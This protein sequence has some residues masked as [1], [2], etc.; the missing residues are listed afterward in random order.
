MEKYL[1]DTY[2]IT[3]FQEQVM[4]QSR[5]LGG[6][7][8]GQS[9]TLRK[10]MGK[11]KFDLMAQLKIKFHDGCLANEEFIKG[12]EETNKNPDELINK[13]WKDWES[14]AQYAFNKSH[15]VC[16]ALLAYQTGYLKANYPAEYMSAVMSRNLSDIKK[17]SLFMEECRRMG[18]T[19][20]GPS[21]QE[22]Y[23]LFTVDGD[24]NIRFG[25]NAIKGVGTNTVSEI[26][27][28][29]KA[30]GKFKDI[31][32]FVSR[33]NLSQVNKKSME[34]LVFAGGFDCFEKP[35]RHEFLCVD[36][37]G[38]TF[39]EALVRYGTQKQAEVGGA[40]IWGDM[41]DNA[42]QTPQ[43]PEC[44][45]WSSL[46][47]LKKEKEHIGIY[48]T[49][50]P[51][52]AFK[53]E[54]SH[55]KTIKIK[56]LNE[57]PKNLLNKDFMF[58]GLVSESFEKRNG[59]DK[60]Y[61][62]ITIEDYSDSYSFRLF[63]K[64]YLTFKNYFGKDYLLLIKAKMEYWEQRKS[65]NLKIKEI[66]ELSTLRDSYFKE[67]N[68]KMYASDVTDKFNNELIEVIG[69]EKGNIQ[70]NISLYNYVTKAR[71]EMSARKFRVG[72]TDKFIEFLKNNPVIQGYSMK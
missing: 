4:L 38:G 28:N 37:Q 34:S 29:R 2:G 27:A 63:G 32:D 47:S 46:E 53:F 44:P 5:A 16:Y 35:K 23:S 58:A 68:L 33:V 55:I 43:I 3:V 56:E 36:N 25:L 10:A 45:E 8:R 24:N 14:F 18:I 17:I 61:G 66:I 57:D 71:V 7:T 52:D 11:K 30:E 22:S 50:H 1:K 67:V 59:N 19:V 42:V 41:L 69:K 39:L 13:I 12:C 6:F 60:L 15:S 9:D 54:L 51:L 65:Y 72:V 40:S 21:V 26:I 62:G 64:D 48:L 20:Y 70:L 49:A 31:F